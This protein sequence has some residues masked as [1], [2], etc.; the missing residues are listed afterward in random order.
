MILFFPDRVGVTLPYSA[1]TRDD[2]YER[3]SAGQKM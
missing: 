3:L 1:A 2:N